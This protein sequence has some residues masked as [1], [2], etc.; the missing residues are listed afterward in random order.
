MPYRAIAVDPNNADLLLS[1][2]DLVIVD[3]D[4]IGM[5]YIVHGFP[6]P[7]EYTFYTKENFHRQWRFILGQEKKGQ[8]TLVLGK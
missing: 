6:P 1:E 4:T 7:M 3:Y 5:D 2:L 8:F